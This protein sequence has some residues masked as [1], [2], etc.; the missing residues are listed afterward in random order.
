V[1]VTVDT[2]IP[3]GT[4]PCQ[5]Q[6]PDWAWTCSGC[7]HV[8]ATAGGRPCTLTVPQEEDEVLGCCL[9]GLQLLGCVQDLGCLLIPEGWI[10]LLHWPRGEW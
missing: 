9:N 7:R 8:R 1:A 10:L 3:E 4:E 2:P 6:A 5:A